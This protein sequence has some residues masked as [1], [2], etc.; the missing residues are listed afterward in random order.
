MWSPGQGTRGV[1]LGHISGPNRILGGTRAPEPHRND[2]MELGKEV[3]MANREAS[4]RGRAL[5]MLKLLHHLPPSLGPDSYL[6]LGPSFNQLL[7][8]LILLQKCPC[9]SSL[10][11]HFT[12]TSLS[13]PSGP[14]PDAPPS[15]T[16]SLPCPPSQ[17]NIS[18][19]LSWHQSPLWVVGTLTCHLSTSVSQL[20]NC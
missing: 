10:S 5:R 6:S 8:S 12:W 4:C 2:K 9:L 19:W 17:G 1:G 14:S 15:Y 18:I 20:S 7:S 3:R 11:C 13:P 16:Q